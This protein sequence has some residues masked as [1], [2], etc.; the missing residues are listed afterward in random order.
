MNLKQSA[1]LAL[2]LIVG[3]GPV[4]DTPPKP[5]PTK[6]ASVSPATINPQLI[7]LVDRKMQRSKT[8]RLDGDLRP[9]WIVSGRI[10]NY[11]PVELKSVTIRID[12]TS[13]ASSQVVDQAT[14]QIDTEIPSGSIGSFSREIQILPP[15]TGWDWSYDV[16]KVVP[17]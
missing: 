11:S 9:F 8:F 5:V 12:V 7:E 17:K 15:D 2:L 13:R 10:N 14:L 3:C 1:I 6:E 16:V 4:E